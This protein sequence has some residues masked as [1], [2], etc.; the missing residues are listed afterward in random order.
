MS[1]TDVE[2]FGHDLD[3][4]YRHRLA[5]IQPDQ[6]DQH[7]ELSRWCLSHGL[8]DEAAWCLMRAS[9]LNPLHPKLALMEERLL[10]AGRPRRLP[11]EQGQGGAPAAPAAQPPAL[12]ELPAGMVSQFS[13]SVQPILLN[14]C[15]AAGCHRQGSDMAYRL[16]L[17]PRGRPL[18]QRQTLENLRA[19]LEWTNRD[20]A[21]ASRLLEM[22][23]TPHGAAHHDSSPLLGV[24]QYERL[25]AWV[26]RMATSRPDLAQVA[27]PGVMPAQH[28]VPLPD[29]SHDSGPILPVDQPDGRDPF[30]PEVFN[31][32]FLDQPRVADPGQGGAAGQP[33][34]APR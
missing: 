6:A 19:T 25:T 7:L 9:Q 26:R 31:R 12:S 5:G 14:S 27:A 16:H 20:D 18:P 17:P 4:V 2:F 21:Q 29:E 32:Q 1:V 3:Q 30:D 11:A 13:R 34:P 15:T 22:A 33:V 8:L 24:R 28:E 23:R 10:Q